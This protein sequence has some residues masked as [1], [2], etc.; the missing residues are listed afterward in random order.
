MFHQEGATGMKGHNVNHQTCLPTLD[1]LHLQSISRAMKQGRPVKE[2]A[3]ELEFSSAE[4]LLTAIATALGMEVV[5]LD[6]CEVSSSIL[7]D[8]PL[9]LIHRHEVFPIQRDENALT[10]AVRNPFDLHSIDAIGAL[11]KMAIKPVL[12]EEN[13]LRDLIKSHLG[14]GAET[15]DGLVAQYRSEG[16]DLLQSLDGQDLQDAEMAQ[17]ASVV[18]LVNEILTEA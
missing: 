10:L 13:Q 2:I 1:R 17:Q 9:K 11:L 16:Q 6:Q 5:D 7:E 18:R 3:T 14:V 4:D 12:V 8:F 15:L